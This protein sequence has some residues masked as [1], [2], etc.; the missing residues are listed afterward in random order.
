[1][2]GLISKS[3]EFLEPA[4]VSKLY[5]ALVLPILEY[6]NPVWGLTFVL[7]QRKIENVQRR[8]TQLVPSIRNSTYSERLAMLDLSSMNYR[9]K[10]GDLYY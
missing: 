1:M 4:M 8:A 3:F 10:R 9:Q 6:S 5:K 7:D 2:L